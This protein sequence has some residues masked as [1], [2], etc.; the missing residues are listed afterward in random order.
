[1]AGK[2]SR[3]Y[4]EPNVPAHRFRGSEAA[5]DGDPKR[6]AGVLSERFE[7]PAD[8][9]A[10]PL[11]EAAFRQYPQALGIQRLGNRSGSSLCPTGR[12]EYPDK[13]KMARR[14]RSATVK[15]TGSLIGRHEGRCMPDGKSQTGG[16]VPESPA[17]STRSEGCQSGAQKAPNRAPQAPPHAWR[18]V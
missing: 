8:D 6:E 13:L 9:A 2:D 3:E 15:H 17:M 16:E 5:I 10:A 1:M 14:S 11:V 18:C 12:S 7:W 4:V